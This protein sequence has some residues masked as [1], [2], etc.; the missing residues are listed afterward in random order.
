MTFIYPQTCPGH[1]ILLIGSRKHTHTLAYL[2][3][4]AH[5]AYL[6]YLDTLHAIANVLKSGSDRGVSV[7]CGFFLLP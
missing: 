3:H 6:A 1:V 7:Y 4:L 5:L 2:A